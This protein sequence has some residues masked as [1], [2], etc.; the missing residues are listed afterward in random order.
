MVWWQWRDWERL[1]DWMALNGVT[2]PLAITARRPY[3][4]GCGRSSG[5]PTSRYAAIFT[6]PAHLPWHQDVEPRL[7]AVAAAPELARRTGGA[8]AADRGPRAGTEHETRAA[9]LR[10]ACSCGAGD[11]LSGSQNLADE[12]VGRFRGSLP[13]SFP[14]SARSALRPD[15][16]G[17]P[18]RAD[19]A[20]RYGPHLR[21]RSLQRGR[22]AE[23]GAGVPRRVSGRSTTRWPRPIRRPNGSR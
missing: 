12:Q 19:R 18:C 22:S 10:R 7:L 9:G 6:G 16:A 3:G 4:R 13:Q 2:L 14:R 8:A 5:S 15:S 11:D 21:S 1:I 23:L 17:V 20:F